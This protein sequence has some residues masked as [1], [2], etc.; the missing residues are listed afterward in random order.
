MDV[1]ERLVL[2]TCPR[3]GAVSQ[4]TFL[5][6]LLF[7]TSCVSSKGDRWGFSGG[8]FFYPLPSPVPGK[9]LCC[10]PVSVSSFLNEK[11]WPGCCL[12]MAFGQDLFIFCQAGPPL[13]TKKAQ[14]CFGGWKSTPL[15][16]AVVDMMLG[17]K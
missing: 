11:R 12:V 5:G 2:D 17:A 13:G 7:S 10:V 8:G 14:F 1:N 15:N 4:M 16:P 9:R 3:G 6:S